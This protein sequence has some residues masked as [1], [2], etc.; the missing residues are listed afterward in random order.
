M[1]GKVRRSAYRQ[2][3][4]ADGLR[5]IETGEL[6]WFD[7]EMFANFNTGVLEQYLDE[8]N[9]T[10]SFKLSAWSWKKIFIAIFIGSLFALVNQYVGLKVGLVVAGSWYVM[11]LLGLACVDAMVVGFEK[12][13][14][15][16]D[17][18]ARVRK[19]PRKQALEPAGT[20]HRR[21]I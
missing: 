6:N 12:V 17:F 11:F 1:V 8:K 4:T 16:D 9:R 5:K 7:T 3:V 18:A 15:I 10:E 13:E 20:L 14:E 21:A 2:P 19:V